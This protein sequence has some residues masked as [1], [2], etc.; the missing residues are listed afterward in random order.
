MDVLNDYRSEVRKLARKKDFKQIFQLS[1]EIRDLKLPKIG[2]QI[3]D[4]S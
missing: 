2:I 3:V 1:D 4:N